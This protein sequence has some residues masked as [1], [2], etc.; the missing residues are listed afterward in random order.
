MN[1]KQTDSGKQ[2]P[3]ESGPRP[4]LH[5]PSVH[6][7]KM[8]HLPLT[9]FVTVAISSLF[10]LAFEL[11][12]TPPMASVGLLV[13]LIVFAGAGA[14][15]SGAAPTTGTRF[16][17]ARVALT[18][19]LGGLAVI[20]AGNPP[21]PILW[22]IAIMGVAAAGF[23]AMDGWMA[24]WT[25]SVSG[26]SEKLGAIAGA[27]LVLSLALLV[28]QLGLAGAWV[29]AAGLLGFVEVAMRPQD[30]SPNSRIIQ[31][32]GGLAVRIALAVAI[33]P[34][35]PEPAITLLA[36]LATGGAVVLT[37]VTMQQRRRPDSA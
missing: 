22:S 26:F 7:M 2:A 1:D 8:G 5:P 18:C 27:L 4:T 12:S 16:T 36:V 31:V 3:Y 19:L 21:E 24:R 32:W 14:K 10:A 13:V 29:L 37:G 35:L 15:R 6:T 11:G 30:G 25:D 23:E 17:V 34:G 20:P 33:A 28:W 9:V